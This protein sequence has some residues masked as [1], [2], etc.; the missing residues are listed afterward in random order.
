MPLIGLEQVI[1]D[2][3]REVNDQALNDLI[4][5]LEQ[6][7]P[8]GETEELFHSF[9]GPHVAESPTS[10]VSTLGY[11]SEHASWTDEGAAPHLIV[12][13]NAKA[14]RFFWSNGPDGPGTYFFNSV[15]HPGQ[16]GTHWFSDVVDNWPDY[17]QGAIDS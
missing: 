11:A 17:V 7:V 13:R 2:W 15:N 12:P 8:I 5:D 16:E 4:D 6:A 9:Y 14:L 3:A 10:F 1:Q